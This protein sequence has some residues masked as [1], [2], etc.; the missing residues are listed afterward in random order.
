MTNQNFNLAL[1]LRYL[2]ALR[3]LWASWWIF[4]LIIYLVMAAGSISFTAI[5]LVI[6]TMA[7]TLLLAGILLRAKQQR[8]KIE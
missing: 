8:F 6:Q 5:M 4:F 3:M 2:R 7:L 1:Q